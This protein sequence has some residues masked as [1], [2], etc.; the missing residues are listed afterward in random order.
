MEDSVPGGCSSDAINF[1]Q[2]KGVEGLNKVLQRHINNL[3]SNLLE[4]GQFIFGPPTKPPF[5]P[6]RPVEDKLGGRIDSSDSSAS[7]R[8]KQR[9]STSVENNTM[10]FWTPQNSV[11]TSVVVVK[12]GSE[13]KFLGEALAGK[14][15]ARY[16]KRIRDIDLKELV[17]RQELMEALVLQSLSHGELCSH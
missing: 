3:D 4:T 16:L 1:D 12:R 8:S 15:K 13:N 5:F 10:D 7:C 9:G 17:C 2:P 11:V 6:V 14:S